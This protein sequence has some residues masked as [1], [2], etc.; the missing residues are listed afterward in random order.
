[1]NPADFLGK[2]VR[3]MPQ[4]KRDILQTI[5]AVEAERMWAENFRKE[6]FT[7]RSFT[8]WAPRKKP[9][10]PKRA[11]LVKTSTLKGHALKGRKTPNSVDFVF[12]LEYERVHNEGLKAGRGKGFIMPKRQFIG[13]SAELNKRIDS[14]VK[15]YLNNL[16]NRP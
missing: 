13:P 1:M 6:G 16:L 4:I 8:P 10:K 11:L 9:E 12:P 2:I 3:R 5:I 14:K 7:D 15:T